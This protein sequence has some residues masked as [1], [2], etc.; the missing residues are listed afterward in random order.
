MPK[1]ETK[2]VKQLENKE[3]NINE[4]K[5]ELLDYVKNEVDKE[6]DK[7]VKER[8]RKIIRSKNCKIVFLELLIVLL[9]GIIIGGVFFFCT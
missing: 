6:V 3:L 4:I 8:E 7:Q 2:E 9:I 1:K 5:V